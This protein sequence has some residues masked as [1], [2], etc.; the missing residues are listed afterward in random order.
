MHYAL[1]IRDDTPYWRA[2]TDKTFDDRMYTDIVYD[3]H[4]FKDLSHRKH[5]TGIVP[6]TYGIAYVSVGMNFLVYDRVV[7]KTNEFNMDE[8]LIHII[9]KKFLTRWMRINKFGNPLPREKLLFIN[10]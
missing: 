5:Y 4:S 10:T 7:L 2:I 3:T 6:N 9:A 1:S 8:N